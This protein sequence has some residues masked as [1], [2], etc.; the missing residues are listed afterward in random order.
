MAQRVL[1]FGVLVA[2]HLCAPIDHLPEPGELVLSDAL[3]LAIGGCAANAAI[4]L[5][6]CGADVGVVG[7]VGADPFGRFVRETLASHG[8]DVQ[9]IRTV[10]TSGTSGTLIINVQGQDRRFVHT[11][12]ANAALRAG[13]VSDADLEG[14]AVLYVGG[15]LLMPAVDPQELAGLFRRARMRGVKTLLDVVLPSHHDPDGRYRQALAPVLPETDVFLPNCD[16]AKVITGHADPVQQAEAF[17]QAGAAT[18]VITCGG[19]GTI[20]IGP[21]QRLRAGVYPAPFVGGTGAGDAFDAGYI[22]GVLN[23]LPPQECLRWGSALGASC[24]QAVGATE[25]VFNGQ[26]AQA[27]LREHPLECREF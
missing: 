14:V 22:M 21:N 16:E 7:C 2:D 4:D 6:K 25:G 24:V 17:R 27:F 26:Q 9:R 11:L 13:D 20:L 1:S 19:E 10:Q 12:G 15:Y 3:P 18:A 23:D 8:V 5:A